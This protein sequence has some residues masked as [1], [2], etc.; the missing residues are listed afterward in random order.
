[1]GWHSSGT[2][3]ARLVLRRAHLLNALKR[4]LECSW[5]PMQTSSLFSVV[6]PL[7]Y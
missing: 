3:V 6:V 4:H 2:D 5:N 1:M 7:W